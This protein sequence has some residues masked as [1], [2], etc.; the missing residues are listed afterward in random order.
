MTKRG[1]V[2]QILRRARKAGATIERANN[3]HWLVTS[4]DGRSVQVS[5]S[6]GSDAAVRTIMARLRRIGVDV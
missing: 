4:P 5:F 3:S 1:E 2:A 6:P